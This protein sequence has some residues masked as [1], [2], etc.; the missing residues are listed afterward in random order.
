[1]RYPKQ[2][3]AAEGVPLG[4]KVL[5]FYSFLMVSLFNLSMTADNIGNSLKAIAAPP[6]SETCDR[7][8]E[9]IRVSV[10]D[11]MPPPLMQAGVLALAWNETVFYSGRKTVTLAHRAKKHIQEEKERRQTGV[12]TKGD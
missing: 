9:S 10:L 7:S 3:Y 5:I 6:D 8:R 11:A 12:D 4:V 2:V 1:M